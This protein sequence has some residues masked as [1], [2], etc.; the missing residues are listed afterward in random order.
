MQP[1]PVQ[2]SSPPQLIPA[3]VHVA[4]LDRYANRRGEHEPM[5][6]PDLL[7]RLALS[8]L[9]L[10]VLLKVAY[11]EPRQHNRPPRAAR[12]RLNDL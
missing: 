1:E 4:R 2:A 12:L 9:P 6:P 11:S 8:V 5:F 7:Q 10:L 3:P